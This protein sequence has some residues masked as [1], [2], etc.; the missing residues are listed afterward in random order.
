MNTR[1][2]PVEEWGRIE[3]S[4]LS[5]LLPYCEPQNISVMVVEDEAGK[6]LACVSALRVT[7][8]EGLWIDPE[9]RGDPGVFRALIRKAYAVPRERNEAWVIGGAESGNEQMNA[10]CRRLGGHPL[11]VEFFAMPVGEH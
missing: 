10:L 2:L 6:I 7:H 4:G 1:V 3:G 11:P 8:F 9:H 5:A